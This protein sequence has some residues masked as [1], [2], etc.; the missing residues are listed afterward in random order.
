MVMLTAPR[1]DELVGLEDVV[2]RFQVGE[3]IDAGMLHP[4]AAY[5]S[6]AALSASVIY[7]IYNCARR[8]HRTG[9]T[10]CHAGVLAAISVDIG[11]G[12]RKSG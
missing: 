6:T 8:D 3:A 12:K 4:N 1:Q 2:S 10:A 11:G 9:N 7:P 5:V